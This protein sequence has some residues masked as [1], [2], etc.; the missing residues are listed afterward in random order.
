[1]SIESINE[2]FFIPDICRNTSVLMIVVVV[3]I[4]AIIVV[5]AFYQNELLKHLGFVSLYLLWVT[6]ISV[7]VLCRLRRWIIKQK[8][9]IGFCAALGICLLAFTVVELVAQYVLYGIAQEL[10]NWE[11]FLR[12]LL[13]STLTS[14]ILLRFFSLLGVLESRH[15]VEA[16]ARLQAL[17]SRIRPHFLFNSLN[18]IAELVATEPDQAEQAITS[19]SSLF[20][21]SLDE[22]RNMHTLDSE[23][24]LCKRYL[25]LE[26][27]R[28]G[29]KLEVEWLNSISNTRTWQVPKLILQP[30][31]ENMEG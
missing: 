9:S 25:D 3:E 28:S 1:M 20:R 24:H 27:W 15:K 21:A 16:Q 5:L 10:I 4:L 13:A 12:L 23:V 19:L 7:F 6:L 22:A 17:Q 26:R 8:Y 30:L 14:L 31:I 11:R 18:T 2:K 29:D